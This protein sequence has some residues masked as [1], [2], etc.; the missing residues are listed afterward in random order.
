MMGK[1]GSGFAFAMIQMCILVVF[2]WLAFG[3]DIFRNFSGL[4]LLIIS[5]AFAVSGFGIL[6]ASFA[7]SQKQVESLSLIIILVMSAL[8]GSMM[9]LF[10]FPDFLKGVAHFTVNYW[11]I[12]GFYDT[13]GRDVGFMGAVYNAMI[14]II[15]AIISSTIAVLVFTNRLKKN[16]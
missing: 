16:Y 4:M 15:F 3:L 11:A 14:L 8:G 5:V 2:S 13:L 10:L 12:D 7:K 1:F 6:I 9:P